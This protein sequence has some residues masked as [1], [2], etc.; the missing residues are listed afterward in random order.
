[1]RDPG[2]EREAGDPAA[3][4]VGVVLCIQ[5]SAA[6]ASRSSPWPWSKHALRAADAA[7]VEAQH[8]EAAPREHVEQAVHDRLFIVPPCSGCGCRIIASGGVGPSPWTIATLQAPV[9]AV[10]DHL[11]HRSL[12]QR[13]VRRRHPHAPRTPDRRMPPRA[14][15][16]V[17]PNPQPLIFE[18]CGRA[19]RCCGEAYRA[20]ASC[21]AAACSVNAARERQSRMAGQGYVQELPRGYRGGVP[22]R[23][24]GA[25]AAGGGAVLPGHPCAACSIALA[26][27]LWRRGWLL[28]ARFVSQIGRWHDRHRDPSRARRSDGGFLIDHGMGV[29]IGETAEIG[30]DVTLYQGVTLGGC[31]LDPGK[32]HPTLGDGVVVGAGA[33]VLGPFTVGRG[34]RIGSN[35][36]VVR[37]VPPGRHRGRHPGP[38]RSG[39]SRRPTERL[40][41]GL[42]RRARAST[43]DPVSRALDRLTERVRGT[44]LRGRAA[45]A[46]D[47]AGAREPRRRA[48][49]RRF[50]SALDPRA[51]G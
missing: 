33:A 12:L 28:A 42:R 51:S 4:A 3:A 20:H 14:L 34:A 1:M 19:R 50:L 9:R 30:D 38:A 6:A 22:A 41:P 40:L 32:R 35:A 18:H 24:G 15:V 17:D 23:S 5:S 16:T 48:P 8:R 46:P 47:R 26:H 13:S 29:V 25:L 36:V 27:A 11:R 45:R 2:A 39:R 7:E 31:R 21:I 49:G 43:V 37:E 44:E 10:E